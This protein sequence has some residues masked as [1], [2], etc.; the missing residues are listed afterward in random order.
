LAPKKPAPRLEPPK[1]EE[2]QA[3]DAAG[4]ARRGWSYYALN[5]YASAAA[6]FLAAHQREPDNLDILYALALSSKQS[7]QAEQAQLYFQKFLA[8]AGNIENQ[9]RATMLRRL[10]LGHI[11]HMK[12]GD[13]ELER[14][15]WHRK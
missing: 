13:W 6:D 12:D 2:I 15:V 5:L 4:L 11:N 10:A 3:D 14:E 9:D 7:G 1:P 8:R